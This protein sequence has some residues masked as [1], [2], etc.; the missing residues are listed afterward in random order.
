MNLNL[1]DMVVAQ[2]E[3]MSA[4]L[5]LTAQNRNESDNMTALAVVVR[6][7]AEIEVNLSRSFFACLP[8]V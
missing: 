3:K 7:K 5:I 2:T 6:R 1:T 8:W 4:N